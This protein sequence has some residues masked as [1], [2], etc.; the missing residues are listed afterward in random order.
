MSVS[1]GLFINFAFCILLVERAPSL[2]TAK[3]YRLR[4]F[5]Q[6]KDASENAK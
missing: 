4:I 3:S 1:K 2:G 5:K 6:P